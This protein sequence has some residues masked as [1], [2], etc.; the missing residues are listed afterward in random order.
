[1]RILKYFRKYVYTMFYR[2][3]SGVNVVAVPTVVGLCRAG[4]RVMGK[5]KKKNGNPATYKRT[6]GTSRK[7]VS[8]HYSF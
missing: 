4:S 7:I 2:I 6:E 1:M 8:H 3:Y 5:K